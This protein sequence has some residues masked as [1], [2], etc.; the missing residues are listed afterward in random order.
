MRHLL[1]RLPKTADLVPALTDFC[2]REKVTRG[3]ISLI[4]ALECAEIG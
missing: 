1:F 3:M 4:G 2:A